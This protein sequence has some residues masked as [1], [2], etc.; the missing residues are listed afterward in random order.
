[1]I[2]KLSDFGCAKKIEKTLSS[3]LKDL[4]SD[5]IKGSIPWMAPEVIK[6]S[7]YGRKA[8]V[9][10]LGCTLIELSSGK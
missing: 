6:Q 10:S 3:G 8:D 9:W 2:V 7:S 1:M 5:A 4:I